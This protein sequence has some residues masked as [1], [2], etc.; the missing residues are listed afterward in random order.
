MALP[1]VSTSTGLF[2]S[3][4][5]NWY[6]RISPRLIP[7][8]IRPLLPRRGFLRECAA[9]ANSPGGRVLPYLALPIVGG[10]LGA[11]LAP[12][13]SGSFSS[14]LRPDRQLARG[15]YRERSE[16]FA[17]VD[18]TPQYIPQSRNQSLASQN[19]SIANRQYPKRKS[20]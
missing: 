6:N 3:G 17:Y 8:A 1:R 10:V 4:G 2:L 7:A 14:A 11:R 15:A 18:Y 19:Q 13:R 16:L 20:S 12:R 5:A 9:F